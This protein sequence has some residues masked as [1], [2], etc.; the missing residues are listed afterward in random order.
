M[1]HTEEILQCN[2]G[3]SL[4][5]SF[6]RYVFFCFNSLV[7][8]IAVAATFHDTTSLLIYNFH[9]AIH[10]HILDILVEQTVG[11]QQLIHRVQT[12]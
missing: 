2:G 3:E 11:F 5:G 7:Q 8:A 12:F 1:I 10:H 9:F 4:C 6:Y